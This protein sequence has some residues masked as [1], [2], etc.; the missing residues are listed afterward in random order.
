MRFLI[1]FKKPK[2][3]ALKTGCWVKSHNSLSGNYL[4]QAK[5]ILHSM[6]RGS[7]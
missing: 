2:N 7:V 3:A 5:K 6:N 4:N 1:T